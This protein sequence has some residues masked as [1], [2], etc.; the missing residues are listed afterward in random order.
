MSD[1]SIRE[2][3]PAGR[4]SI[5]TGR[6]QRPALTWVTR[7]VLLLCILAG[8]IAGE[9]GDTLALVAVVT[10]IAT[11]LLRVAWLVFRWIQERDA[12]FAAAGIGLLVVVATGAVLAALGVGE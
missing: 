7:I 11:P 8:A 9:S 4:V 12:R 10:V 5:I 6:W 1:Q 3:V 2:P